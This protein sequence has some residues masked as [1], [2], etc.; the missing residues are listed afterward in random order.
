MGKTNRD[1]SS[2]VSILLDCTCSI[3]L[4]FLSVFDVFIFQA[5][6]NFNCICLDKTK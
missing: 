3:T 1:I 5:N 2:R 4:V 6:Q